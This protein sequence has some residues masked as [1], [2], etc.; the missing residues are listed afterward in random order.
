MSWYLHEMYISETKAKRGHLFNQYVDKI[1]AVWWS[2]MSDK[3]KEIVAAY[4]QALCD[5]P[6]QSGYPAKIE[7]PVV[8]SILIK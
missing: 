1:N 6:G 7:W 2:A 5:I 8:P 4:R 3:D